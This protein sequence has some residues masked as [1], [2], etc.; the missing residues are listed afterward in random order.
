MCLPRSVTPQDYFFKEDGKQVSK[1]IVDQVRP[2]FSKLTD[3]AFEDELKCK[4]RKLTLG[5]YL[6]DAFDK[7]PL[8]ATEDGQQVFEWCKRT[9]CTDEACSSLY[10]VSASQISYYTALEG[11]FFNT[12]GLLPKLR[13][14]I[15]DSFV[16]GKGGSN[17]VEALSLR[18]PR[19]TVTITWS[20][21]KSFTGWSVPEVSKTLISRWGSDSH[22]RG[23]YTFIP[24][25]VDGVKAHKALASPLPPKDES[26]GRK[27]L[28]VLFA[29][30]ATHVNFYTT[31]HGAYLT[32]VREAERLISC[33][34]D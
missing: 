15:A 8:A 20:A 11:G 10:E 4:H 14:S 32:G 26:R 16:G 31:T 6:D 17:M 12:L 5:A 30:E 3:K 22:V 34:A 9:E 19:E 29:G 24:D 28:Q 23:S 33:Y 7:S 27:H 1:T 2:D 25:G 21:S 13:F 18:T